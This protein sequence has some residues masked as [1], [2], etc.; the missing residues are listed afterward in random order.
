MRIAASSEI[1][2]PSAILSMSGSQPPRRAVIGSAQ[3]GLPRCSCAPEQPVQAAGYL[4][5]DTRI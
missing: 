4:R 5:A 2:K 1:P 3:G